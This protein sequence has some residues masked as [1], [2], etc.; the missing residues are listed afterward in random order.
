MGVFSMTA[1]VAL[2]NYDHMLLLA[3]SV[4]G[5]VHPTTSDKD[6]RQCTSNHGPLNTHTQGT[7]VLGLL[8][9]SDQCLQASMRPQ[10]AP[11]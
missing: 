9:S 4:F 2:N 1:G 6:T 7:P 8:I 5:C 10:Q 3:G 11:T